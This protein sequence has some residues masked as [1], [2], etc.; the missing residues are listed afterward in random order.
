MKVAI[1][2]SELQLFQKCSVLHHIEGIEDI[3]SQLRVREGGREGGSERG[4]MRGREG[5]REGG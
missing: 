5:G 4:G 3:K 1:T 2:N